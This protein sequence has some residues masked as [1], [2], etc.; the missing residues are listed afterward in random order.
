MINLNLNN[1][2]AI[3]QVKTVRDCNTELVTTDDTKQS[4][5]ENFVDTKKVELDK[6]SIIQ[7]REHIEVK[8]T[9]VSITEQ[10]PVELIKGRDDRLY[11]V[12]MDMLC[13]VLFY[14]IKKWYILV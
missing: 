9:K 8:E 13:R 1:N 2:L 10:H 11:N 4:K 7:L 12:L 3:S 14:K 6:Q 5:L